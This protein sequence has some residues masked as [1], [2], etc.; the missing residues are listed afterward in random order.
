MWADGRRVTQAASIKTL[1]PSSR[2]SVKLT[3]SSKRERAAC[4]TLPDLQHSSITELATPSANVSAF[5]QAVL[6][7]VIPNEFWGQGSVQ[8]HNK[9]CFL[10]KI[11]HFVHLRRFENMCLHEVMQGMK[12]G[13]DSSTTQANADNSADQRPRMARTSKAGR[14]E[15]LPVGHAEANRVILRVSVL[16]V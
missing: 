14:E 5:C 3:K 16:F 11:H 12:V 7:K 6:S 1:P 2:P 8:E 10:K 13:L 9:S 4:L 15:E